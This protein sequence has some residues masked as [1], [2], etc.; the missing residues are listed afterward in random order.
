MTQYGNQ[1]FC[2]LIVAKAPIPFRV[3]TRL[4]PPLSPEQA[5]EIAAAALLDTLGA[6]CEAV[7]GEGGAV[8]V[9]LEGNL[10]DAA[11]SAELIDALRGTTMLPQRGHSFGARLAHA[12]ADAAAM[13]PG[14]PII[15]IGM[16]TPQASA[17]LLADSGRSLA[18]P[19]TDAVFGPAHDGGW[20]LLGLRDPHQARVLSDIP[21]STPQTGLLTRR[22][23]ERQG[24]VVKP[25]DGL[26]DVDV[27]EDAQ[28]VAELCSH[29][30]FAQAVR[31]VAA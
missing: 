12:H 15:Q 16:D 4:C 26:R 29:T 2:I 23:L 25:V 20:W 18:E 19:G 21:T 5:A 8:I 3:K 7:Q 17:R 27:W 14:A 31:Q 9:A 30:Q 24:L 6:S 10:A 28:A 22:A 11:R 13:R 1:P